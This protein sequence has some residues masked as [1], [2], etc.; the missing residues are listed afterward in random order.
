VASYTAG[1]RERVGGVGNGEDGEGSGSGR[2]LGGV[3]RPW[4]P[5]WPRVGRC[6]TLAAMWRAA[7]DCG[8]HRHG[9]ARAGGGRRAGEAG[10]ASAMGRE[11]GRWPSKPEKAF[12]FSN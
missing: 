3:A 11:A 12:S 5:P 4:G 1:G 10:P 7:P 2:P 9:S 6:R 8:H